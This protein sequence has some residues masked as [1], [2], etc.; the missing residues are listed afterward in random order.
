MYPS[1]LTQHLE[2]NH[3]TCDVICLFQIFYFSSVCNSQSQYIKFH[4]PPS[5]SQIPVSFYSYFSHYNPFHCYVHS[6]I[7]IHI[8]LRH[9]CDQALFQNSVSVKKILLKH[10]VK[11][12]LESFFSNAL[13]LGSSIEQTVCPMMTSNES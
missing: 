13:F 9:T 1:S 6:Q 11:F 8:I 3:V 5:N 4:F 12:K 2:G 7:V 10:I